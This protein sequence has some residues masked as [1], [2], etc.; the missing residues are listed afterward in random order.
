MIEK[1]KKLSV[2]FEE[3]NHR[4]I[5]S[6]KRFVTFIFS[7]IIYS[8]AI[9]NI[10]API[11]CRIVRNPFLISKTHDF[12]CELALFQ[13]VRK[14]F[15]PGQFTQYFTEIRIFRIFLFQQFAQVPDS[16]R[17]TLDKMGL[18]FEVA[19]KAIGSKHLQSTEKYKMAKL[20]IKIRFVNWLVFA[21]CFNIF[22]QQF[23]TE[24]IRIF[25]FCL[26]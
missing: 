22:L 25:C 15:Q 21:E 5:Q 13:I 3:G 8:A 9:K 18:L 2:F 10:A 12:D 16:I 19:T 24:T 11:A 6:G 26:P 4:F 14:L 20:A 17:N 23:L 1:T 7:G